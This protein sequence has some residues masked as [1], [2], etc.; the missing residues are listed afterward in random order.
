MA[1]KYASKNMCGMDMVS[2]TGLCDPQWR[3]SVQKAIVKPFK[4]SGMTNAEL[5]AFV[6]KS[7]SFL[8]NLF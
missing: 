5:S 6:D 8:K 1:R 4:R 2:W 3:D 7:D